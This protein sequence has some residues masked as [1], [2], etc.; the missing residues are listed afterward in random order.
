MMGL[1]STFG[2]SYIPELK[3][4]GISIPFKD[5]RFDFIILKPEDQQSVASVLPLLNTYQLD[6]LASKLEEN[7]RT[8]TLT[9]PKFTLK[10]NYDTINVF[11]KVI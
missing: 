4:I 11:R 10:A 2:Y 8:V 7:L 6:K 1:E 3:S 9:L 5:D